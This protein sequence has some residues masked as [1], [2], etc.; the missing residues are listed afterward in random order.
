VTNAT[1]KSLFGT[2]SINAI[3]SLP[4][5]GLAPLTIYIIFGVSSIVYFK[6]HIPDDIK[7]KELKE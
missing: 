1:G 7:F 2:C 6:T 3:S 5:I 4:S